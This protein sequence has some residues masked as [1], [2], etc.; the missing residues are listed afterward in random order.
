VPNYLGGPRDP[1]ASG[2]ATPDMSN[3]DERRHDL[4]STIIRFAGRDWLASDLIKGGAVMA[5]ALVFLFLGFTAWPPGGLVALVLALVA[6]AL[7][8]GS[9]K[10]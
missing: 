1:E 2:V 4:D 7:A 6:I 9:A 10:W 5:A 3:E 8:R